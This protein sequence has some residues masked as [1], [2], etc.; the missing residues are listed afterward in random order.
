M[1]GFGAEGATGRRGGVG[2]GTAALTPMFD[3]ATG[4]FDQPMS[5]RVVGFGVNGIILFGVMF[6]FEESP[7]FWRIFGADPIEEPP[8][9]LSGE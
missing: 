5:E 3:A 6:F 9:V 1:V 7:M 2:V 4:C 8:N